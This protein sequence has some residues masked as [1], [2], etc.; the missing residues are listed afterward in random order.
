[1]PDR[2]APALISLLLAL[3]L[4]ACAPRDLL[5]S[6]GGAVGVA[7][8]QERGVSGALSD[9]QLRLAINE[10]WF[11]ASLQLYGR[12]S[13]MISEG[14]VVIIG[15]VPTQQLVDLASQLAVAAG[16]HEPV[17][18]MTVGPDFPFVQRLE[19]DSI[20]LR[21]EGTYTFDRDVRALNYDVETKDG[22][23]YLIGEA[24]SDREKRRVIWLAK[25]FPGVRD[26]ESYVHVTESSNP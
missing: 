3:L 21:L 2:S 16:A 4:T 1:M 15:R 5:L 24:A 7:S 12:A 14:R 20:S 18:R 23:V 26:V 19:D 17:N 9:Y 6:G 8:M 25:N 11:H 13:L 22:T 10:A